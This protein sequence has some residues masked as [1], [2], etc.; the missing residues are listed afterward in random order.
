MC[1]WSY[2]IWSR[3]SFSL[4]MTKIDN[5]LKT[6]PDTLELGQQLLC[7]W[8]K[9]GSFELRNNLQISKKKVEK[10]KVLHDGQFK[11]RKQFPRAVYWDIKFKKQSASTLGLQQQLAVKKAGALTT[12]TAFEC[13]NL[14]SRHTYIRHKLLFVQFSVMVFMLLSMLWSYNFKYV[15]KMERG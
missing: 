3:N 5:N 7:F 6:A 12:S 11:S 8:T 1:I 2:N 14:N 4:L 13:N 15:L 9:M 10:Y